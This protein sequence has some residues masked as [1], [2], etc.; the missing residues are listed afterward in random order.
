MT[1][2]RADNYADSGLAALLDSITRNHPTAD[3]EKSSLLLDICDKAELQQSV[4]QMLPKAS[5]LVERCLFTRRHRPSS[6][7]L[8]SFLPL[9]ER[10]EATLPP[11]FIAWLVLTL[12]HGL[13]HA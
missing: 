5:A 4:R 2:A 1:S 3:T 8:L 7:R 11:S 9:R 6:V 12:S 10:S 13:A